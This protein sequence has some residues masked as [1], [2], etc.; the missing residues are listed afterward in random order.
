MIFLQKFLLVGALIFSFPSDSKTISSGFVGSPSESTPMLAVQNRKEAKSAQ[1][2]R[3]SLQTVCDIYRDTSKRI[4]DA[5]FRDDLPE[6]KR[7]LDRRMEAEIPHSSIKNIWK[8]LKLSE[9]HDKSGFWELAA[10]DLGVKKWSCVWI[11]R[12]HSYLDPNPL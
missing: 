9:P 5:S 6:L 7:Y 12:V 8:N 1:R 4:E 3:T 2:M 10:Q 11:N